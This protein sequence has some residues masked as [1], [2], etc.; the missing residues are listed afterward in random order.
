MNFLF[1][2]VIIIDKFGFN[3]RRYECNFGNSDCCLGFAD[4][5]TSSSILKLT[6]E[7]TPHRLLRTLLFTPYLMISYSKGVDSQQMLGDC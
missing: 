6:T 1:S 5:F 2:G 7:P 4:I 3:S